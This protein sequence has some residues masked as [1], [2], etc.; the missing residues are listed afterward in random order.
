MNPHFEHLGD[1]SFWGH[2]IEEKSLTSQLIMEYG[3]AYLDATANLTGLLP[4][5][6]ES[7]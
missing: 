5:T 4:C 3:A 7:S 2:K 1:I 6:L